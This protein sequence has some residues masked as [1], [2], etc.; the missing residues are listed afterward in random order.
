[1]GFSENA[2][3]QS[4]FLRG[5]HTNY[6]RI[7]S[8]GAPNGRCHLLLTV[9]RDPAFLSPHSRNRRFPHFT[10]AVISG[11]QLRVNALLTLTNAE[12]L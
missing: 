7:V 9:P 12:S 2:N 11:C 5:P 4:G 1:V 8:N 10:N 6:R 3:D